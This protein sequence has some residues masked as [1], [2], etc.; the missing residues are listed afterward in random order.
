MNHDATAHPFVWNGSSLTPVNVVTY[1][2]RC[3][4]C[5]QEKHSS[6]LLR[7]AFQRELQWKWRGRGADRA[8]SWHQHWTAVW[9]LAGPE[10]GEVPQ[11]MRTS[12]RTLLFPSTDSIHPNVVSFSGSGKAGHS[13]QEAVKSELCFCPSVFQSKL[14]SNLYSYKS[15][16]AV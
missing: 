12:P 13:G 4:V 5:V 16:P 6:I 2:H 14:S 9:I 1:S 11:G 10:T 15:M 3:A 8:T 7:G